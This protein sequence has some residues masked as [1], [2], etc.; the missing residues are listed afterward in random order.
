MNQQIENLF[1]EYL[2]DLKSYFQDER[3]I[4]NDESA[5]SNMLVSLKKQVLE[6]IA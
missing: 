4:E 3:P 2:E 1:A 6:T 5:M